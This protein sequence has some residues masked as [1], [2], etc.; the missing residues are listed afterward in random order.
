VAQYH[1]RQSAGFSANY[2]LILLDDIR[3]AQ[4]NT[5]LGLSNKTHR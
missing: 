5:K 3:P 1:L 2:F 4:K